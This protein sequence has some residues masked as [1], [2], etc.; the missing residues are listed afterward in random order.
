[1][2][3]FVNFF[4][5]Y[6]FM[7]RAEIPIGKS[8]FLQN[9]F[10]SHVYRKTSYKKKVW[11]N[12]GSDQLNVHFVKSKKNRLKAGYPFGNTNIQKTSSCF[13]RF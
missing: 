2:E 1:M 3:T 7:S 11:T 5:V 10:L 8:N 4:L 6:T 13:L 9:K 12:A